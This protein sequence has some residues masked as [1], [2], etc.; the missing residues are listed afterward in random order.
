M[1]TSGAVPVAATTDRPAVS[2]PAQD[3]KDG[4]STGDL[5]L[6]LVAAGAAAVLAG[7]GYVRRT[8]RT[9]R[10]RTRT[11]PG[12]SPARPA[13]GVPP[14]ELEERAWALLTEADDC[15]R[16]SREELGFARARSDAAETAPFVR[17]LREAE[18]ELATAFGLRQR[19]DAGAP[20]DDEARRQV[21][22]GIVGRCQEAGRRLDAEAAGFDRLRGLER[23]LAAALAVAEERFRELAARTGTAEAVAADL[24]RHRP[25]SAAAEV[26]GHVE[27]AKD[28]LLFA[29]SRLNRARQCADRGESARAIGHLRAAEGAIAQAGVFVTGVDRRAADL[30]AAE[31]LLPAALTGAEAEIAGARERHPGIPDGPDRQDGHDGQTRDG[32]AAEPRARV[33]HADAVLAAVREETTSGPYD[34]VDALRRI[35]RAAGPLADGRAGVLTA[36]ARLLAR[37][38]VAAADDYVTTHR[39]AVGGAA[40]SR[41]AGAQQLLG[42]GLDALLE[43]EELARQARELAERDVRAYGTPLAGA[44]GH[45]SG[46]GGAVLGGILLGGTPAGGPPAGFGGPRTRDRHGVAAA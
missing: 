38:A 10:T 41:L 43:A 12:G 8:R 44:A 37:G 1:T 36:A 19:Y 46:V 35:V 31:R 5:V 13:P 3:V 17:A 2:A 20:G 42:D 16:T 34:P 45:E 24:R 25:A 30:A 27:Q 28:R 14:A 18:A 22:A 15:V 7:Y 23:D 33:R 21:L 6:P 32:P 11:T 39:G 40:R 9:R 26:T 4:T 29:T